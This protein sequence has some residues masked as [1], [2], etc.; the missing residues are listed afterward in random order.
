MREVTAGHVARV[1]GVLFIATGVWM[2][3]R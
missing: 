3:V 2:L 1:S